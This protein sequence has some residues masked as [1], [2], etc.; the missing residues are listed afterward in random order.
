MIDEIEE[1]TQG[2][3]VLETNDTAG[4]SLLSG[5]LARAINNDRMR[6][7]DRIARDSAQARQA[8]P[9]REGGFFKRIGRP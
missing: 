4:H 7:T 6:E 3:Q 1:A 5:E 8:R 2:T 9:D